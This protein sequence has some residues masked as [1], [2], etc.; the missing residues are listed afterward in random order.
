MNELGR[1]LK[2][3]RG[4][5]LAVDV[6]RMAGLSRETIRKVEDGVSVKFSTLRQIASALRVSK[7]E[8]V[9][10]VWA[11]V[12]KEVGADYEKL[13]ED[14]GLTVEERELLALFRELLPQER[15]QLL[16]AIAQRE[17]RRAMFALNML[18]ASARKRHRSEK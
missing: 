3:L 16:D 10:L 12:R 11:W 1:K 13:F 14:S 8:W 17:V 2:L 9:D 7:K 4:D 18:Y 6:A 5:R 15:N